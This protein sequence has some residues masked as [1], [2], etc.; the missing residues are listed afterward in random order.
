MHTTTLNIYSSD[1]TDPTLCI[2]MLKYTQFSEL[3]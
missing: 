1:E 3:F 2:L